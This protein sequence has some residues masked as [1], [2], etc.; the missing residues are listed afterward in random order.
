MVSI[1]TKSCDADE[2]Q[3]V[4]YEMLKRASQRAIYAIKQEIPLELQT[5]EVVEMV[6]DQIKGQIK[7]CRVVI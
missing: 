5:N 7:G 2:E 4:E 3:V 1:T 6:L